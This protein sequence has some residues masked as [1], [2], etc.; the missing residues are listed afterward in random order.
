MG[1]LDYRQVNE[2]LTQAISILKGAG[3]TPSP[4]TRDMLKTLEGGQR[5]CALVITILGIASADQDRTDDLSAVGPAWVELQQHLAEFGLTDNKKARE[6]AVAFEAHVAK[7]QKLGPSARLDADE[8]AQMRAE[9]AESR[10]R[11]PPAD[12]TP[13]QEA[14]VSYGEQ[15]VDL[16][17]E[18][19]E[20]A[21]ARNQPGKALEKL[22]EL[23]DLCRRE[24]GAMLMVTCGEAGIDM[25]EA[26]LKGEIRQVEL[27]KEISWSTRKDLFMFLGLWLAYWL[28]VVFL[29]WV[30]PTADET[31]PTGAFLLFLLSFL[32]TVLWYISLLTILINGLH[33]DIIL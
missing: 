33:L 10:R 22:A 5:I 28:W 17:Q 7:I 31:G 20:L 6:A 13:S 23:R 18:M 19:D 11:R 12:V 27:L 30:F 2:H 4:E 8:W 29:D 24:P 21:N 1:T 15:A 3:N 25:M 32:Y 14:D 26:E 16:L 9:A